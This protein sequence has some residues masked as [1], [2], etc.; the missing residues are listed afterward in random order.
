MRLVLVACLLC[1]ATSA[2]ADDPVKARALFTDGRTL[3]EAAD[4][5]DAVAAAPVVAA[6]CDKF[7]ASLKLDSQLGT[8]LNLADCRARQG[9]LADA[10]ALFEDAVAEAERKH[11]R[12]AFA[13]SQLAALRAKIVR[14]TLHVAAPELAN[15]VLRLGDR[16]LA[17]AE[18]TLALTVPPGRVVVEASAPGHVPI[19]VEQIGTAG[20]DLAIDVPAL[21]AIP[22]KLTPVGDDRVPPPS[23][24]PYI[25]IGSGAGLLLA[26]VGIGLHAKSRY[27]SAR[28]AGLPVQSAQHEGNIGTAVAIT[29]VVAATVGVVLYLRRDRGDGAPTVTPTASTGSVG[30]VLTSPF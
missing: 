11:D 19:H 26:S 2:R 12:E 1:A 17:R 30:L 20:A 22:T 14:V 27:T 9:K 7:A 21:V 6:A 18:W 16:E 5:L 3:I 24:V 10:Y 23:K 28:D 25:V 15:L 29:G 8:K 4:K 13:K